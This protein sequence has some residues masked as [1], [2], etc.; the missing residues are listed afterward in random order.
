M[1]LFVI[2]HGR[3]WKCSLCILKVCGLKGFCE[4]FGKVLVLWVEFYYVW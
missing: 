2:M 4:V 1:L 3:E